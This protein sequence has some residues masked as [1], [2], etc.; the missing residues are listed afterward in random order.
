[1]SVTKIPQSRCSRYTRL[2]EDDLNV[3]ITEIEPEMNKL[4]EKLK[5][6]STNL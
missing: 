5:N 1:V 3:I 2:G 4:A 6:D